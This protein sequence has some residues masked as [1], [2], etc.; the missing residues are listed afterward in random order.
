MLRTVVLLIL[1]AFFLNSCAV[2]GGGRL[3]TGK[4][5]F[6]SLELEGVSYHLSSATGFF[7]SGDPL[8]LTLK[9]KN[10][11]QTIKTFRIE[12]NR[13][14]I[15]QFSGKFGNVL[16]TVDVQASSYLKESSFG[17]A[18]GEERSFTVKVD[19]NSREFIENSQLSCSVR[20]YFLPKMF[21]RNSLSILLERK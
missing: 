1:S 19:T 4:P 6:A 8:E 18:P 15:L 21:R 9:M 17:L 2:T 10:M 11:S 12:K 16:K 13:L 3:G 7:S 5:K 20:L 14:V